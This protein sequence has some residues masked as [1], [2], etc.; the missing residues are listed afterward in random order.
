MQEI[1]F[2]KKKAIGNKIDLTVDVEAMKAKK[3]EEDVAIT[4]PVELAKVYGGHQIGVPVWAL[5]TGAY[6]YIA[7]AR[8]Q[9]VSWPMQHIIYGTEALTGGIISGY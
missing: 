3:N 7:Y 5:S 1:C 8:D 6:N 9:V 4:D 2:G